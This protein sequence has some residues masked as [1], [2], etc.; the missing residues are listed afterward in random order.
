VSG[1]LSWLTLCIIVLPALSGCG[2]V[3]MMVFGGLA[4]AGFLY[5]TVDKLTEAASPFIGA[6]CAEYQN[7][8]ERP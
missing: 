7:G 6:A 4:S 1:R 2:G 3:P 8:K 5:T